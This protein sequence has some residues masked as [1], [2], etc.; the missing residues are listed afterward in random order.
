M[1]IIYF[2]YLSLSFIVSAFYPRVC[3]LS[4]FTKN[5]SPTVEGGPSRS[6]TAFLSETL[7][8]S[9]S[10][11]AHSSILFP[12]PPQISPFV[13]SFSSSYQY[14][15]GRYSKGIQSSA[16][17]SRS[18]STVVTT[19]VLLTRTLLK[20]SYI[21]SIVSFI[22]YSLYLSAVE[23][24]S[25]TCSSHYCL[26]SFVNIGYTDVYWHKSYEMHRRRW[27]SIGQC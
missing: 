4:V 1:E 11:V 13:F 10:V 3:T 7:L 16:P 18:P 26:N 14:F 15:R 20:P 24:P 23:L 25:I 17:L 5:I 9:V 21:P 19:P 6:S 2:P 12:P 27:R 22:V 8:R